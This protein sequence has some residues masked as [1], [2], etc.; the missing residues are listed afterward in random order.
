MLAV[1]GAEGLLLAVQ[2]ELRA[3]VVW[4][5]YFI[6]LLYCYGNGVTTCERSSALADSQYLTLIILQRTKHVLQQC[7]ASLPNALNRARIHTLLVAE[8]GSKTPPTDLFGAV[9][10]STN[11]RSN[12]GIRRL[13][14][15]TSCAEYV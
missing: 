8:S 11:T 14:I 15:V 12:N 9:S 5:E 2:L 10:F 4:Q 1:K 6:T 13:A 7:Q 3:S